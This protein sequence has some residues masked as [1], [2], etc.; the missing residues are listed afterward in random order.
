AA[1]AGYSCAIGRRAARWGL[2]TSRARK[3][4]RW[5]SASDSG[6]DGYRASGRPVTPSPSMGEGWGGGDRSTSGGGDAEDRSMVKKA[7][8]AG[9]G[10]GTR[11]LR[12]EMAEADPAQ[13]I[14]DLQGQLAACRAERDAGLAREA[15]LAEVLQTTN[16][17]PGDLT[18]VFDAILEKAHAL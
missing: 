10:E 17:S 13:L 3:R 12:R 9:A 1:A 8:S 14:A 7:P 15:A 4:S 11:T 18:P 5:S 6:N 16:S 2:S